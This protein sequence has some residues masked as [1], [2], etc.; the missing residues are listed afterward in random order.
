MSES[1]YSSDTHKPGQEA[2]RSASHLRDPLESQL[3]SGFRVVGMIAAQ[4]T[5][6]VAI[7][8]YFGWARTYVQLGYFGVSSA[9]A[10]LSVTDYVLR[11]LNVTVRPLV[12]LGILMLGILTGL[13]LS[14]NLVIRQAKRGRYIARNLIAAIG[15]T[16]GAALLVAGLL[17]FYNVIIYSGRYPIVPIILAVG[18]ALLGYCIHTV[19]L[20][21]RATTK[22]ANDGRGDTTHKED[23]DHENEW[24]GRAQTMV[25]VIVAV[26]LTFWTVAVYAG[27]AGQQS[28]EEIERDLPTRQSVTV[29]SK[30]N[31]QL[32]APGVR[33]DK[34]VGNDNEYRYRYSGLRLLL[35]ANGRYI[36]LPDGWV[37]KQAPAFILDERDGL[38]FELRTG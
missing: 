34:I 19:G 28:G 11:S 18:I 16:V 35:Y 32:Q 12:I 7:L 17:G 5:V 2:A 29:Y 38:R 3:I 9:V 24:V 31:L 8:Y 4:T 21:K 1:T 10:K 33:I 6:V 37:H 30:F 22:L 14:A 36:L 20:A 13:H 27:N 23:D 26:A 25:I 15:C